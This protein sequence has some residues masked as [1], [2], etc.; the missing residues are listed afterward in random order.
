MFIKLLFN[1]VKFVPSTYIQHKNLLEGEYSRE[2]RRWDREVNKWQEEV[3]QLEG[4]R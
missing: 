3:R 2:T 1:F 4:S